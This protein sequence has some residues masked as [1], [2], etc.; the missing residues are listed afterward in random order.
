MG[1]TCLSIQVNELRFIVL[2][3]LT[4]E[5]SVLILGLGHIRYYQLSAKYYF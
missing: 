4:Q 3:L 1:Y 2:N 5:F